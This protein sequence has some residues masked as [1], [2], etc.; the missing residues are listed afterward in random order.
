MSSNVSM[1]KNREGGEVL[2]VG[3]CVLLYMSQFYTCSGVSGMIV[4]SLGLGKLIVPNA[5]GPLNMTASIRGTIEW[6]SAL[7]GRVGF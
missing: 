7:D 3:L 6:F 1:L 4:G 5:S 2:R